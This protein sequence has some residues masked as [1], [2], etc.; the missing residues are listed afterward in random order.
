MLAVD[1]DPTGAPRPH[2]RSG[3]YV[4]TF[5]KVE[6]EQRLFVIFWPENTTWDGDVSSAVRRNRTAFMRY[7]ELCLNDYS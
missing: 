5:Q 6:N 2:L 4:L 1:A 7:E 3:L